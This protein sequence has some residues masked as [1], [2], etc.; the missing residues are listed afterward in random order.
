MSRCGSGKSVDEAVDLA[1]TIASMRPSQ[2]VL[3]IQDLMFRRELSSTVSALNS[4]VLEHPDH[5]AIAAEALAKMGLWQ[6]I[7][8]A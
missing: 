8:K 2:I 6:D 5:R 1:Q 7:S 3:T 4:L